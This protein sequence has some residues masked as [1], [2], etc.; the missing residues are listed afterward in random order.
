MAGPTTSENLKR[1]TRNYPGLTIHGIRKIRDI[2]V[3]VEEYVEQLQA[4]IPSLDHPTTAQFGPSAPANKT[5][6]KK[7]AIKDIP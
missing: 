3:Q 7:D 2:C 1:Q 5:V 4:S 6:N